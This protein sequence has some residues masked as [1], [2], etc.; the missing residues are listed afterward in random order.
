MSYIGMLDAT[1]SGTNLLSIII[2]ITL[3][4]VLLAY[5]VSHPV[6]QSFIAIWT[7]LAKALWLSYTDDIKPW[8]KDIFTTKVECICGHKVAEGTAIC[9]LCNASL[10]WVSCE[11]DK[12]E[13]TVE[14]TV[15]PD[16]QERV[17][18]E[19]LLNEIDGFVEE[20][21]ELKLLVSQQGKLIEELCAQKEVLQM[22]VMQ[23]QAIDMTPMRGTTLHN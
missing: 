14:M 21:H 11:D 3:I 10:S 1:H 7:G 15:R 17:T 9:P 18:N 22:Q 13:D 19:S 6:T 8:A 23:Y 5:A 4:P 2:C 12:T 20:L 16:W